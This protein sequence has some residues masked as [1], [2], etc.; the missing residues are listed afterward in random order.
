MP[1]DPTIQALLDEVNAQEQA[2]MS[3]LPAAEQRAR[4]DPLMQQLFVALA[5][6]GPELPDVRDLPVVVGTDE[7]TV[8]VYTPDAA[9]QL[10]AHVYFHGGAFWL[11]DLE[12]GDA[13]CRFLARDA[14]CVVVSVDYR[15]APEHPFPIPAEDCYAATAWVVEH[16]AELGVDPTR[17]SV[18]G[19]SAGGILAAAVSLMARDRGGPNLVFQVLDIPVTDSRM[20]TASYE[21]FAEGYL[22]TR[23]AME[24]GWGYYLADPADAVNPYASPMHATDLAGLPP[25]LI[26]T[27]Q[28]DPLRDEGE[29]YGRRLQA[30]GVPATIRRW[31]GMIHGSAAF[32]K[33]LPQARQCRADVA[34]LLREAYACARS[35]I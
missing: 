16:A 19:A 31:D 14:G 10:P 25:A 1:V 9:G 30:A 5:E 24:Q 32:T 26:V 21:D 3:A 20:N 22:L 15:L 2:D 17:V 6:P 12:Q 11:G 34:A 8:R 13:D 27:A 7:I 23:A 33:L 18:G 29:E 28:Y 4:I 35:T